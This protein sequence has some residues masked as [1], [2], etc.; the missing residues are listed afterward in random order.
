MNVEIRIKRL[1]VSAAIPEYAHGPAEDAGL[2]LTFC[3]DHPITLAAGARALFTTGIS[4]EIPVGFEGQ[5]RSRSGLALSRGLI[6]L[7][8][9]GTIDPGYRGEVGVILVNLSDSPQVVSPGERIAQLVVGHYAAVTFTETS[10]L[11]PSMRGEAGFGSS[12]TDSRGIASAKTPES[13]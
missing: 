1:R 3:G 9:P 8:A 2:D 12:D 6:V 13:E 7:N 11:G 4:L 5:I 10:G